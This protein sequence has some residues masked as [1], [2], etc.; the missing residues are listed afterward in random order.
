MRRKFKIYHYDCGPFHPG[1]EPVFDEM[2]CESLPLSRYDIY[3]GDEIHIEKA[4]LSL[5]RK[6]AGFHQNYEIYKKKG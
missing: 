4:V 1:P 2:N 6:A 5:T 3:E